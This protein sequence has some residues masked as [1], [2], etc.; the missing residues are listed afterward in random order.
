MNVFLQKQNLIL[1]L[2]LLGLPALGLSQDSVRD[3]IYESQGYNQIST[4]LSFTS[5]PN[6][7]ALVSPP[8]HGSVSWTEVGPFDYELTYTR[9]D[10]QMGTDDFT[11]LVWKNVFSYEQVN[12]HIVVKASA[13]E[14]LHD[15]ATTDVNT[16]VSIDVL[17]NDLTTTGVIYLKNI[18]L[19][20]NGSASY[21]TADGT[22][23]FTPS[24]D[25]EGTAYLNYVACDSTG[26]CDNGTVSISVLGQNAGQSDTTR[27]FTKKNTTLPVFI[28]QEYTLTQ[29]P[30]EGTY[31]NDGFIPYYE[32]NTDFIGTDYITFDYQGAD[33]VVEIEVMDLEDNSFAVDDE[34]H[35]TPFEGGVEIDVL[36]N[37]AFGSD[38]SCVSLQLQPEYGTASYNPQADGRGVMRYTPPAGFTGVDWFTYSTCPPGGTGSQS[39]TA[40]VYVFV[41]KYEP[42]ATNF[43]MSTP[44]LTPLVV[45]YS[46]PIQS[47]SFDIVESGDLGTTVFLEGA[48]DTTILGQHITGYNLIIYTPN[49]D[50]D[51]G[52]DEIELEYCVN[53]NGSCAYQKTVKI[54]IDILDIGDGSAPMCFDD[55]IWSGD[56][57]FD[58]IVDMEDLLTIGW[59]IGEVGIP[60]A[61]ANPD[62]W[63]GKYG[64]DWNDPFQDLPI[65]LK[66]LDTDGDSLI[67]AAD[68]T[69]ISNFYGNAHSMTASV[70]PFYEDEIVLQGDLYVSPGDLVELKMKMG[71]AGDPAENIY[72]FTFPFS[73]NPDLV[74]P[75]S[76]SVD[77]ESNSWL[78]YN[79][80]I[81]YM[82][83]DD[84]E[85]TLNAGFTRTNAIAAN[86]HGRIGSVKFIVIDDIDGFRDDDGEL[87][88][89]V[90]GG[91]STVM[92]G[93]GSS[94]GI[95]IG[96]ATI[97]IRLN[98]ETKDEPLNPDQLKL[99]PNP[100][101]RNFINVHL[102]GQ[103]DFERI[104]VHDL[105]GRPMFDSDNV[106]TNRMQISVGSFANGIY[107]L[108]AY[109]ER[110]VVNKKFQVIR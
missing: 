62:L 44:K 11:M 10:G 59:A 14:C 107:I 91:S 83:R 57:N 33:K 43:Q 37:D 42:S 104:V 18:P 61:D 19:A 1:L 98:E 110:G 60:R 95:N 22:V 66:H 23:T 52:V 82:Q 7:P 40:T 25:F 88:L 68:T 99:Y 102:N 69:A 8:A 87:A 97:H 106:L 41:S 20:N 53:I 13:V 73:Y 4:T 30:T 16:P 6:D 85:G 81:L 54:D 31:T 50:V 75:G 45:G 51:N 105:T 92:N 35:M 101:N 90:G 70:I 38:A 28:P 103:Q 56:A 9:T 24:T 65:D 27:L 79:S 48:V 78:S 2:V 5:E 58:G 89:Q 71:T 12:F 17:Q 77:F 15:H 86:G 80:P 55:C 21:S 100:T 39:E 47:Y 34:I 32:P 63:Y 76:V 93:G 64:D 84:Q 94:Y 49:G 3:T 29:S 46:V 96:G 109:T 108:S 36:E 74:V 26:T 67:T 72:G